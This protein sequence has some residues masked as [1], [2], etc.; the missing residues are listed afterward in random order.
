MTKTKS[1]QILNEICDN[2][3]RKA[4]EI[5]RSVDK[6]EKKAASLEAVMEDAAEDGGTVFQLVPELPKTGKSGTVYVTLDKGGRKYVEYEWTGSSFSR[7]GGDGSAAQDQDDL[8]DDDQ[9]GG[10]P[11]E[12]QDPQ[13][14]QGGDPIDN[15]DGQD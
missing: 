6:L 4:K 13:D 3:S 1:D 14:P 12:T 7:V 11:V 15:Q 10:D 8:Q 5:I 2:I 9:Q